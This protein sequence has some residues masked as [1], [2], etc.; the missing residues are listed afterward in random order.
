MCIAAPSAEVDQP[1]HLTLQVV[2]EAK[3]TRLDLSDLARLDRLAHLLAGRGRVSL[4]PTLKRVLFSLT[5][6]APRL[7]EASDQRTDVELVD[8][9]RL[10]QGA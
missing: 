9:H 10:Y 4:S 7:I 1:G 8:L 3:A 6:F 5:G 2:G